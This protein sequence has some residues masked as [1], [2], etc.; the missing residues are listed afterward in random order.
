MS[1]HLA[2][3]MICECMPN[4]LSHRHNTKT[5]K[6]TQNIFSTTEAKNNRHFE[7][8]RLWNCVLAIAIIHILY[9]FYTQHPAKLVIVN[10]I[11]CTNV[12]LNKHA[13]SS[14]ASNWCNTIL[15]PIVFFCCSLLFAATF[16][17]LISF[18]FHVQLFSLRCNLVRK[19][20][21]VNYVTC[22]RC[23]CCCC[24]CCCRHYRCLS[25]CGGEK[26]RK[27][28]SHSRVMQS[29]IFNVQSCAQNLQY[30][31]LFF[32]EHAKCATDW[33]TELTYF[34][35]HNMSYLKWHGIW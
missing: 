35:K 31:Q 26:W 3:A 4:K 18:R 30:S 29:N 14:S 24:C 6:Y 10:C 22:C 17:A 1:R 28:D 7:R 34:H 13:V 9:T 23:Y 8:L 5:N 19:L 32:C 2:Y 33:I 12:R 15:R 16:C 20:K 27:P 11:V 21:N 25:K